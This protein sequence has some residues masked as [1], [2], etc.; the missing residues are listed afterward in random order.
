[1]PAHPLCDCTAFIVVLDCFYASHS[2]LQTAVWIRLV[3]SAA[4]EA[5]FIICPGHYLRSVIGRTEKSLPLRSGLP[6][7]KKDSDLCLALC[8]L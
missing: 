7:K 8:Y 5:L 4:P 6:Q 2:V 1:M 3:S